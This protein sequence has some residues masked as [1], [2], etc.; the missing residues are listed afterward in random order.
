MK[1]NF[2]LLFLLLLLSKGFSQVGIGTVLP[3]SSA[4]L[5]I[6]SDNKGLL[7]PRVSLEDTK[8]QKTI[9]AGN[10]NSLLV[11][12][13]ASI[14]DV[15]PGFYYWYSGKW[16]RLGDAFNAELI[17]K[18]KDGVGVISSVNNGDGTFSLL[19]SD[20]KVFTS[21]DLRG[22]KG[23]AGVVGVEGMAGTSGVPGIPG[24]GLPGAP[25]A[26]ITIVTNDDGVWV[27]NPTDGTWTNING[28]KGDK[29]DKGDAGV[30]GV[31]GMAG[32]SGVPGIPGSGLPGA[33]G[34]G[35]TI[36]TNDDG[37][38]VYNPAEG[39]WTN[40]NGLKGDKGDPGVGGVTTA[41][42][43]I[44]ITGSGT[45][46]EPYVVNAVNN[47]W[48]LLGNSGTDPN[49]NFLGTTDRKDLVFKANNTRS[50]FVD[51][52]S[53]N[54]GY[55]Y[56]IL[57]GASK[58]YYGVFLGFEAGKNIASGAQPRNYYSNYIGYQSGLGSKDVYSSSLIGSFSGRESSRVTSS[59]VVGDYSGYGLLDITESNII[60]G[61]VAAYGVSIDKSNVFGYNAGV[62]CREVHLSNFIGSK[63]G[64][65][66]SSVALSNFIG[67]HAG[68][69]ARFVNHCSFIG[70]YAGYDVTGTDYSNFIGT[71]AGYGSVD[72]NSIFIGTNA[73]RVGSYTALE[74]SSSIL[75]GNNTSHGGFAD[76]IGLGT[77]A[78]NTAERQ[79]MINNIDLVEITGV[80]AIKVP[81]GTAGD[82]PEV[83]IFGQIRYNTTLGRGEMYV[84]DVNGDGVKG[85]FGWRP[86]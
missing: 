16:I 56:N 77:G 28:L 33:P 24:S 55:G 35:I 62:R 39:T 12:N 67:D 78:V 7:I 25:G 6:V 66:A 53:Y 22:P 18:G 71:N 75:I 36:V 10:V 38:W 34:E 26:G 54:L 2:L 83:P 8:D 69:N 42:S 44:L 58:T 50:G 51:V 1:K 41:G 17:T 73:G 29:G 76:S 59:L 84:E 65:D 5:D 27:Y 72:S 47:N 70:D 61:G 21:D 31:E 19:Y 85:D 14:N 9:T 20:G 32:T 3:D 15:S 80:G 64:S 13:T 79:L 37:V 11:F 57:S 74:G 45:A 43:D 48:K 49:V 30:V 86:I 23:D 63:T 46:S 68:F 40:I 81:S 52:Y 60:G 82:R 4:Q